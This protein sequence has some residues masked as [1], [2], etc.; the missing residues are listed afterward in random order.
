ML[1]YPPELGFDKKK[2]KK[3]QAL[4]INEKRFNGQEGWSG[5]NDGPENG[6]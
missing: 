2:H 3:E 5:N 4:R 1:I 6:S